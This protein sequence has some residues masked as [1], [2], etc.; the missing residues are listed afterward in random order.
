MFR[1][2][3]RLTNGDGEVLLTFHMP[4]GTNSPQEL[5][6]D[7]MQAYSLLTKDHMVPCL[8]A[9]FHVDS[10]P[11]ASTAVPIGATT[12]VDATRGDCLVTWF[13]LDIV[14]LWAGVWGPQ[15]IPH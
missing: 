3:H 7:L 6:P 11:T 13:P 9:M 2:H 5:C 4:F 14:Y 1:P 8:V 12:P 10:R 15:G